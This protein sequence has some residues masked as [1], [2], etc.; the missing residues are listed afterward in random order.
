MIVA[1]EDSH[2]L[3]RELQKSRGLI[4][5]FSGKQANNQQA[6]DLLEMMI[7]YSMLKKRM[8]NKR[9]LWQPSTSETPQTIN[10]GTTSSS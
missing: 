4:N 10:Y 5:A 2:L 6:Y 9:I 1:I 3:P 7:L 8:L